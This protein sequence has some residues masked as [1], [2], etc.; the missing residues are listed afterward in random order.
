MNRDTATDRTEECPPVYLWHSRKAQIESARG[1]A[2]FA[3]IISSRVFGCITLNH[4]GGHGINSL[5]RVSLWI[6]QRVGLSSFKSALFEIVSLDEYALSFGWIIQGGG[7]LCSLRDGHD[8]HVAWGIRPPWRKMLICV[9][10]CSTIWQADRQM[11]LLVSNLSKYWRSFFL[12]YY[13]VA[14]CLLP[15]T[16]PPTFNNADVCVCVCTC[17]HMTNLY[18]RSQWPEHISLVTAW[19]FN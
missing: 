16:P 12:S 10:L 15:S 6:R 18:S 3:P 7:T 5:E 1:W 13:S 4:P 17:A 14:V 9:D 11:A 8:G 19:S 2:Q